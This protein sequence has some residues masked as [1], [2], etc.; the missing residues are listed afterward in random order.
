MEACKPWITI[1]VIDIPSPTHPLPKKPQKFLPKYDP[2][3]H[4]SPELHIKQ[5]MD[6]LKLM[7]VE[8]D[9]VVCR[10]STHTSRE[11]YKMVL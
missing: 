6:A 2:D 5:F 7:N 11:S 8:H 10:I 1:D 9:D 4:I 3:D